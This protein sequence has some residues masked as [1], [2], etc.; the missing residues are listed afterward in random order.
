[1]MK[2]SR[3]T[4]TEDLRRRAS[5]QLV[6]MHVDS[7]VGHLG[8][9]LSTLDFLLVLYHGGMGQA[10][11]LVLFRGHSVGRFVLHHGRWGC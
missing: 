1:M 3:Q 4:L 5:N 2:L 9:N 6:K 10:D 8:G 7:N 11:E